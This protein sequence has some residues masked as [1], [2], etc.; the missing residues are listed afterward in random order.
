[1]YLF[2]SDK[3]SE[4]LPQLRTYY[5]RVREMLEE[6]AARSR[7]KIRLEVIDPLPFS[8][9]EDRASALGLQSVPVG[10]AG[11]KIY[12]GLAGTN[13]TNGHAAIPFLQPDKEAFLEY[14][15]AKLIHQLAVP[16][17][18]VVDLVSSLPMGAGFD[19]ATRQMR[20]PWAV[21]QQWQQLYDVRQVNAA[22]LKEIGKDVDVLVL[23]QPKKLSDDTAYAIDQFVLRGGHL[24]VF[25]DPNAET[26]EAGAD[27][28]NPSAAMFADKSSNLP[29]LFKAWGVDYDPNQVVIDRARALPISLGAGQPPVRQP[30]ILGLGKSDL[31][32]N[33]V[34]TANLD[35]INVSTAGFFVLAK[36]AR[37]EKLGPLIQSSADAMMVP[38][39]R[40]RM[41][42]DP[43]PLLA[44]YEPHKEP[45]VIA[46][47]L[48]GKFHSAFPERK[49]PGHL[50]ESK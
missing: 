5:T 8:D 26:D 23:V 4:N 44:G 20:E 37:D 21:F 50:A 30:A 29:K 22:S 41:L 42:G 34:V 10:Q 31:N 3:G 1:L 27:P 40:V 2:F 28:N 32:P 36:D 47:R 17:K 24:L 38:S 33:D 48:E 35:S 43:A 12:F 16:K 7:G 11:E 9:A 19:P 46:A 18:P 45:Y 6:M 39:E 13:S 14:D 15:V 49:D 25:V